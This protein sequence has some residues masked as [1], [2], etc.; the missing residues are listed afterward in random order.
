MHADSR[1]LPDSAAAL[2]ELRSGFPLRYLTGEEIAAG[3]RI[4]LGGGHAGTVAAVFAPGTREG[5]DWG[6]PDGG[7]L[8]EDGKL[9]LVATR[10]ADED[11]E[12]VSRGDPPPGPGNPWT[13]CGNRA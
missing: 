6:C 10:E 3:D 8:Y 7:F 11:I 4:R 5:R 1:D 2:A 13:P 9:G 12:F